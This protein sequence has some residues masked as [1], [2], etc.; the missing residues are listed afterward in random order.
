M[1]PIVRLLPFATNNGPTNM[2]AD[3]ALLHSAVGG[4]ASLRFYAWQPATLSLGYFQPVAARLSHPRRALPWVRRPSGGATLVHD[5]ELT[6]C[7]ALPAGAGWQVE[8][9]W[10]RRMH[11]VIAEALRHLGLP[12]IEVAGQANSTG[13][14]LCFQSLTT[15]DVCCRGAKIAGSA[16]RK[17]H[18]ALLQ[19]GSI[20][21]AQSQHAPE[22][23]GIAELTGVRIAA[24]SLRDAILQAFEADTGW[25]PQPAPWTDA[26]RAHT[27]ELS[28]TKYSA[29][30]WNEKR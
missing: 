2:A 19:H 6:Y 4:I 29:A 10:L 27:A 7:L 11:R 23:P 15:G 18:G 3:E 5:Q 30:T 8:E 21:L 25:Q 26:E 12:A 17:H 24:S 1:H 22:L 20:L 16:Q 14:Q 13:A 9:S 28:I